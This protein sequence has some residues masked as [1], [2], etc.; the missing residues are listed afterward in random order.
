MWKVVRHYP[1]GNY[2]DKTLKLGLTFD[3]AHNH[4]ANREAWSKTAIKYT[5]RKRTRERGEWY[6]RY[7]EIKK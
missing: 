1:N 7:E 3:E 5:N 4:C 2:S 6:D